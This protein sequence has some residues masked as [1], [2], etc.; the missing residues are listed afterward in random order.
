MINNCI[1]ISTVANLPL[2]LIPLK[3]GPSFFYFKITYLSIEVI[4]K[5]IDR[6]EIKKEAAKMKKI[7]ASIV[8]MYPAILTF[9]QGPAEFKINFTKDKIILPIIYRSGAN[10]VV[11][12]KI[13][14]KGTYN[15]MFDTGSP[16]IL[17]LDEQVFNALGLSVTDS[18]FAGDGSGINGR[19]YRVTNLDSIELG[20]YKIINVDAMVRNYNP[21][22]GID[23]INGVIGLSFFKNVVVELNFENNELIISKNK[24]DV[25]GKNVFAMKTKND[26]P[27]MTINLGDKE[28]ETI[29]DT[30]NMGW[31]TVHSDKI[32]NDMFLN[33]PRIVGRAKTIS[34]E[35]EIK[36]AQLNRNITIGNIIF[37]K[38]IVLINDVIP[39]TNA[40]VRFLKQMNISF[41]MSGNLVKLVRFPAK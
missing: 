25:S 27:G 10:P 24:L 6:K 26:V 20:D 11:K 33:E 7:I 4:S 14:G 28:M 37:E 18:I 8:F 15:F 38:P 5:W 30:G 23:S 12:L 39:G 22:K 19:T 17:K 13:N 36:E 32:S 1:S 2:I 31:L 3:G 34:N 29:F 21:R 35:F 9:A 16:G 41:D 40:G